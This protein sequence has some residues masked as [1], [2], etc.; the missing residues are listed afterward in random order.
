M[1]N[2]KNLNKAD[3]LAALYNS[4]QQQGMGFLDPRGALRMDSAEAAALLESHT[5]FD[6]LRGRVMKVDLSGESFD[7]WPYDR[8]NGEGAA[9]RAVDTI[10]A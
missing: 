5:Y 9:Q 10:Q 8:D 4:S 6:Y 3:V 7:P 1:I 2:I